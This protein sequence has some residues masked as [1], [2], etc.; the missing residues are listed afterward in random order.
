M[1]VAAIAGSAANANAPADGTPPSA[2]PKVC[3]AARA[4]NGA[5]S[6][7]SAWEKWM[8]LRTPNSR[9]KPTAIMA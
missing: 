2:A 3:T 8:M 7:T 6:A 4:R 5:V 9:L 1:P